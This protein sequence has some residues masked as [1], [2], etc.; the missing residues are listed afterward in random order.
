VPAMSDEFLNS[1]DPK[2]IED[3]QARAEKIESDAN[4]YYE[5]NL[6]IPHEGAIGFINAYYLAVEGNIMAVIE[7]MSFIT[8]VVEALESKMS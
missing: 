4:T 6:K 7:L 5:L 3:L 1:F 2:D 8:Q